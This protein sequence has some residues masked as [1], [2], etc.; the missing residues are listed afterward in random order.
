MSKH[1]KASGNRGTATGA[2][3]A[4]ALAPEAQTEPRQDR[5]EHESIQR[6][7]YS[8]W[9]ARGCPI[10]SPDEDWFRAEVE[11]LKTDSKATL[12]TT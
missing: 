6:L 5:T 1:P 11:L 4:V 8:Y 3:T 2:A 10:G 7:A 9:E 12:E